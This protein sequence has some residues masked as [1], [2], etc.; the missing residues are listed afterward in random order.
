MSSYQERHEARIQAMKDEKAREV[1]QVI[2]E[3]GTT[4]HDN[5]RVV[6]HDTHMP[7]AEETDII[8]SLRHAGWKRIAYARKYDGKTF[9]AGSMM[10]MNRHKYDLRIFS[11]Q[12]EEWVTSLSREAGRKDAEYCTILY[13]KNSEG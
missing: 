12:F 8:D 4:F 6:F 2:E 9:Q 13:W 3:L 5:F 7:S 11:P 10:G 1:Q